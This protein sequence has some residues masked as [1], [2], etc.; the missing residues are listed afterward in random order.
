MKIHLVVPEYD[1]QY[2]DIPYLNLDDTEPEDLFGETQSQDVK[3]PNALMP[4]TGS[5]TI[6]DPTTNIPGLAELQR[7]MRNGAQ[8]QDTMTFSNRGDWL[9][10]LGEWKVGDVEVGRRIGNDL[11]GFTQTFNRGIFN[12]NGAV[13]LGLGNLSEYLFGGESYV[14]KAGK[15]FLNLDQEFN[16]AAQQA[17]YDVNHGNIDELAEYWHGAG[18]TQ[19]FLLTQILASLA[20]AGMSPFL[21]YTVGRTARNLQESLFEAGNAVSDYML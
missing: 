2:D 14:K 15:Y 20:G 12:V 4:I 16:K 9:E 7:T 3:T 6:D 13:L 19:A 11:L 21:S 10:Q 8:P 18:T 17:Y 1:E 5:G